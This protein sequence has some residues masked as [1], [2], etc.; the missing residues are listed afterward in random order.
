MRESM[1]HEEDEFFMVKLFNSFFQSIVTTQKLYFFVI[2]SNISD[3]K[4]DTKIYIEN[5]EKTMVI[6]QQLKKGLPGLYDKSLS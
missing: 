1:K 5:G 4:I 2:W 6:I 3:R